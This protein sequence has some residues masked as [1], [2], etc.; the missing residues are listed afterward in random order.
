MSQ[1]AGQHIFPQPR[2]GIRI[3]T[4][5]GI[6][7]PTI[8]SKFLLYL[9]EEDPGQVQKTKPLLIYLHGAGERGT[10]PGMIKKAGPLSVA[11]D[12]RL[13]MVI[14]APQCLPGYNWNPLDLN[15][16]L[17]SILPLL[18]VNPEEVYLTGKSMGGVG[19][20]EFA[21]Q[22][23]DYFAAIAPVCGRGDTT[24]AK[25]LKN[26]PVWAFHGALD[27]VIPP[28]G[29]ENMVRVINR[30]GGRA[31][32]TLYPDGTHQIWD[33]VYSDKAL[34]RWFASYHR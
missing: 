5:T 17:E 32:I 12:Y 3:Y 15:R 8:N 33:R 23:P 24:Q 28:S 29:S 31:R 22:F 14:L 10:N 18:P 34:Y 21:T 25:Y 16:C 30:L 26:I 7:F 20:W 11:D 1:A 2:Q 6:A 9:P 13:Q 27:H 4:L 19:C